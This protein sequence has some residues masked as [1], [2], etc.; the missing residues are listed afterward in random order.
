VAGSE[1]GLLRQIGA[2]LATGNTACLVG[3]AG[4]N[5]VLHGL[6]AEVAARIAMVDTIENAKDVRAVLFEGA[7]D[8]LLALAAAVA[9]RAGPILPIQSLGPA[10]QTAGVDSDLNRLLDECSV[11]T[12]TAAAGGNASLMSL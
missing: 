2:I 3:G 9:A 7:N 5:A 8:D 12:N 6:P 1:A 10:G 4:M 11:S